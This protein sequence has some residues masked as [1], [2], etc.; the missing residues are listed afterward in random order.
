MVIK[1]VGLG[2]KFFQHFDLFQNTPWNRLSLFLTFCFSMF[3]P[4]LTHSKGT[5][6]NFHSGSQIFEEKVLLFECVL[7]FKQR[8]CYSNVFYLWSKAF[9]FWMRRAGQWRGWRTGRGGRSPPRSPKPSKPDLAKKHI[10][11]FDFIFLESS[12]KINQ[13]GYT[14]NIETFKNK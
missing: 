3:Q 6:A 2:F 8:F 10:F 9:A 7:P 12:K 11:K 5:K 1:Y 13:K 4:W 14:I